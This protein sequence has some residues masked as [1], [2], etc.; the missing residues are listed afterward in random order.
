MN[1]S[2]SPDAGWCAGVSKHPLQ[3]RAPRS[4]SPNLTT[5]DR[6][7]RMRIR[8]RRASRSSISSASAATISAGY[9]Y[10]R[11]LTALIISI[12]QN[13][14]ACVATGHEQRLPAESDL[15][16]QQPVPRRRAD[17]ELSRPARLVRAAAGAV[18]LLPRVLHA[19]E[20]DEQ[21]R[22]VL[23]QFADRS[24]R[25]SKDWGRSDDD[26]RH[27]LVVSGGVNSPMEPATTVW[28]HLTHGFQFS[29]I[30]AGLLGAAV[31][32]HV[33]CD[34]DPGHGRPARSSTA[35]HPAQCRRWAP[36]S[37]ASSV[38]L[39]RTFRARRPAAGGRPRRRV[40]PDQPRQRRD[41]ER[42]LRVW[43]LS[44]EPVTDL[45]ADDGRQRAADAAVRHPLPF[46][47]WSRGRHLRLF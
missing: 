38:R 3:R 5:M 19:V 25:S 36:T 47:D 16:Q 21:R 24:L 12:N 8:A 1:I 13:V 46:L 35:L 33:R 15:R 26:Q 27:R 43:R 23:L 37:S 39:S 10:L 18:G 32:H 22:R 34:D 20:G 30:A 29:G 9:Q 7:C 17:L 2:L 42:Q 41:D 28:E 6:T 14:P 4:R 11:G 44:H 31:Q 45:R 40:Q